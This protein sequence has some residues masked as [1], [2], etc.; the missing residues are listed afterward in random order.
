MQANMINDHSTRKSAVFSEAEPLFKKH[1][2]ISI[3]SSYFLESTAD[4]WTKL[5]RK[6]KRKEN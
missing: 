6:K 3:P 1:D 4:T 2:D 5:N